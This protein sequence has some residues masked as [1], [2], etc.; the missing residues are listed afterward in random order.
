MT[1]WEWLARSAVIIP[2]ATAAFSAFIGALI[3]SRGRYKGE[4]VTELNSIRAALAICFSICNRFVGWKAQHIRLMH[5]NYLGQKQSYD[6]FELSNLGYVGPPRQFALRADLR[7]ITPVKVPTELLERHVFDKI[8]IQGRPLA[9]AITL[10][11]VIDSFEKQCNIRSDLVAKFEA[12]KF[13]SEKEKI[14]LYLGLQNSKGL[15]DERF[16]SNI[17]ALV[18]QADDCIF[19]SRILAEDLEAYG[20]KLLKQNGWKYRLG[21]SEIIPADWSDAEKEGLIPPRD[22]YAG[23]LKAF[24]KREATDRLA[25]M[26][27][28]AAGP[29]LL[30]AI[31]L[32]A[33]G[34]GVSWSI[35]Y[36]PDPILVAF[37]FF[38]V[39][40]AFGSYFGSHRVAEG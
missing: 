33:A 31:A 25:W 38:Y 13:N 29:V 12:T 6:F 21:I 40:L 18:A 30:T 8:R 9:A 39:M 3:G 34:V 28:P 37:T 24:R 16:K 26:G 14:D 15:T 35:A 32:S 27:K 22:Q 20:N 7:T 19:F 1:V 2:L 5:E 4:L 10:I 17:E 23:W 11:G 36:S